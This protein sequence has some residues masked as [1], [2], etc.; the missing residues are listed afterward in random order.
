MTHNQSWSVKTSTSSYYIKFSSPV[1]HRGSMATFLRTVLALRAALPPFSPPAAAAP[2]GPAGAGILRCCSRRAP[3]PS[4]P[5]ARPYS[6]SRSSAANTDAVSNFV[7]DRRSS[8]TVKLRSHAV[9][10]ELGDYGGGPSGGGQGSGAEE[11]DPFAEGEDDHEADVI[12][13][14]NLTP[15]DVLKRRA[16]AEEGYHDT[17]PG[18]D[19]DGE[20]GGEYGLKLGSGESDRDRAL[21]EEVLRQQR[22]H[23]SERRR[24]AQNARPRRREREIDARGRAYGR[25]S[26]KTASARVWIYPGEGVISVNRREFVDFFPREADRE[27]ILGPMVASR[28]AGM[29]DVRAHVEGGGTSGKAGAVRHGLARALQSYNPEYRPAM[30]KLGYLTRDPRMVERKKVGRKKARKSPQWVRR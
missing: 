5:A 10:I 19:A 9:S 6:A 14:W 24:W 3:S 7:R 30:K 25:G 16:E 4:A 27:A 21:R 8:R 28:T 12:E 1:D 13:D 2:A 26:R 11:E 18:D 20:G 17:D 29:F 22:E 23:D 15:A